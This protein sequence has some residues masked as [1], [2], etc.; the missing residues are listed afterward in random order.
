MDV[1]VGKHHADD[2]EC[3]LCESKFDRLESLEVH[4]QTCEKFK[5]R[6][7]ELMGKILNELKNHTK[8]R[9]TNA[10]KGGMIYHIKLDRSNFKDVTFTGHWSEDI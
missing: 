1:H 9:H 3:G 10:F 7:C 4:L 6:L 2:F 8:E 5:C